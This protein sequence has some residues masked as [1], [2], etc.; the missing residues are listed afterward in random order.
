MGR[1]APAAGLWLN[2][3]ASRQASSGQRFL[4]AHDETAQEGAVIT[5]HLGELESRADAGDDAPGG[6]GDADGFM[7]HLDSEL[8]HVSGL[9]LF[10]TLDQRAAHAQI[11]NNPQRTNSAA[12]KSN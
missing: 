9:E 6:G 3:K 5:A 7:S 8:Y 11:K 4:D 10:L 2:G 12:D 1:M